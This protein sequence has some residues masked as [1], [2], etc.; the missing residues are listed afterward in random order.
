MAAIDGYFCNPIYTYTSNIGHNSTISVLPGMG[1]FNYRKVYVKTHA[2]KSMVQSYNLSNYNGIPDTLFTGSNP[3]MQ[4]IAKSLNNNLK[5][6]NIGK[7]T[8]PTVAFDPA[9]RLRM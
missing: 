8:M 9:S 1:H 3:I 4:G 2:G 6:N 5:N 7:S